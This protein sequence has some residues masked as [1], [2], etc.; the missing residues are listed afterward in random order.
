MLE[1]A[2]GWKYLYGE[3]ILLMSSAKWGGQHAFEKLKPIILDSTESQRVEQKR[4]RI[5]LQ[6]KPQDRATTRC[7]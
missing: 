7:C 5:S 4:C 3:Y 6:L 1:Q 2:E